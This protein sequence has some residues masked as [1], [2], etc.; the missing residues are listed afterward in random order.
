MSQ[1]TREVFVLVPEGTVLHN[2]G[3]VVDAVER[4]GEI[5]F[6][7]VQGNASRV[8]C[9]QLDA[10]FGHIIGNGLWTQQWDG[11]EGRLARCAEAPERRIATVS[12]TFVPADRLPSGKA[13]MPLER[14]G[15]VCWLIAEGHMSELARQ[16]FEAL[17][18][19]IV[20]NGLWIQ[21]WR[22]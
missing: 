16:E 10:E 17:L 18:Q 22:K 2:G 8:L 7:V 11:D 20:G 19:F 1:L 5:T 21:R 12:V 4:E 6:R 15:A 13:C 9:E 3:K 14:D